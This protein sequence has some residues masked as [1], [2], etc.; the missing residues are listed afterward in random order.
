[1]S[2]TNV[3]GLTHGQMDSFDDTC[4][5][6]EH[7]EVETLSEGAEHGVGYVA[8]G[9]GGPPPTEMP[10]KAEPTR[11]ND[12]PSTAYPTEVQSAASLDVPYVGDTTA[13]NGTMPPGQ[14]SGQDLATP[15]NFPHIP[16][17]TVMISRC[18]VFKIHDVTRTTLFRFSRQEL[19]DLPAL[20]G[21]RRTVGVYTDT[22]RNFI[23]EDFVPASHQRTKATGKWT[24]ITCFETQEGART[25]TDP[26][27]HPKCPGTWMTKK[28]PHREVRQS[29]QAMHCTEGKN[30]KSLE[31]SKDKRF[32]KPA[33]PDAL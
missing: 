10:R 7:V 26:N 2:R 31:W 4:A 3:Y 18:F 28:G 24:G 30:E 17:G 22:G 29:R 23:I 14:V 15:Q 8:D 9:I 16:E 21:K 32:D 25:T 33:A 11:R 13:D 6:D 19:V 20:T 27:D 5:T 12:A 1:M